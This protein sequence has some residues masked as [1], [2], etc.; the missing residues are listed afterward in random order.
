M[1]SES[2]AHS[3][4]GLMGYW[5]IAHLG[6]RNNCQI[7][8]F[9]YKF[10]AEDVSVSSNAKPLRAC[11]KTSYSIAVMFFVNTFFET[12]IGKRHNLISLYHSSLRLMAGVSNDSKPVI[13]AILFI[14]MY[15]LSPVFSSCLFACRSKFCARELIT[16]IT[17]RLKLLPVSWCYMYKNKHSE[18]IWR[19]MCIKVNLSYA[20][21][22]PLL[23][24]LS[25]FLHTGQI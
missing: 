2:I 20:L 11:V 12:K 5:I 10:P 6:S 14:Y 15:F 8:S 23:Y 18:I 9:A 7:S 19:G 17:Q 1:G 16:V 22:C 3:A 13:K 24:W 21:W 4:F 25:L